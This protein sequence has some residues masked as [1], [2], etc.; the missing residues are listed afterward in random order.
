ML[1]KAKAMMIGM[2]GASC[3]VGLLG[4]ASV[5]AQDSVAA[6]LNH[7][8][9]IANYGKQLKANFGEKTRHFSN[10]AQMIVNL[11]ERWGEIKPKLEKLMRQ[12]LPNDQL[13]DQ[14]NEIESAL[15][16]VNGSDPAQDN[17]TNFAGCTQSETS[18]AWF[19]TNAVV[20]FNDSGSFLSTN[21]NPLP[22][23][24]FSFDG[25]AR[26]ANANV[27]A[28][29]FTDKG[30]LAAATPPGADFRDCFGDPVCRTSRITTFYQATL[31]FDTIA[32]PDFSN[33]LV[34][35]STDGGNTFPTSAAAAARDATADF[36]DKPEM[37]VKSGAGDDADKV[38]VVY[39]HFSAGPTAIEVV[40]SLNGGVT[41]G[42]PIVIGNGGDFVQFSHVVARPGTEK[43]YVA[44]EQFNADG[45][46]QLKMRVSS[47]AGATYGPEKI[48]GPVSPSGDGIP[49]D[50]L[51]GTLRAGMEFGGFAVNPAN[52]HLYAMYH[53]GT[54]TSPDAFGDGN[55]YRYADIFFRKSADEG[56]TW[57]APVR[58][59]NDPVKG[60]IDQFQPCLAVTN[61]GAKIGAIFYDRRNSGGQ[62]YNM[63]LFFAGSTNEGATWTNSARS[64]LFAPTVAAQNDFL[65]NP[66]YMGDYNSPAAD[67]SGRSE[68]HTSELQSQR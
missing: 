48:I 56:T 17:L 44:W 66:T 33:V 9:Q 60:K 67:K 54:V 64:G 62:N 21:L 34:F 49:L 26:S 27:A 46:R 61:N 3:V 16:P 65:V 47:D 37:D 59:N 55:L 52:G 5:S 40:R 14:L 63:K 42:A 32:G 13:N 36:L 43:V 1:S 58:V 53:A 38:Y 18:V 8:E 30:I 22:S 6:R 31:G 4:I 25:W 15:A 20:G 19:N 23:G 45:T 12:G 24:N 57:S 7:A 35:K 39:T 10:G 2:V 11:G 51:Q 28:P 68:E 41:W 29:T 50:F